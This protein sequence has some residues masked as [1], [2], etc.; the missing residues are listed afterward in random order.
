MHLMSTIMDKGMGP[1]LCIAHGCLDRIVSN[2]ILYIHEYECMSKLWT[3]PI[4]YDDKFMIGWSMNMHSIN[5]LIW[6]DCSCM[7]TYTLMHG[8]RETLTCVV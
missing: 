7:Y 2:K 1:I 6:K 3:W 5:V 4:Y 8:L